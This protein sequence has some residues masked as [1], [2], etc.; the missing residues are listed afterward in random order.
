MFEKPIEFY[1]ALAAASLFV[2]ERSNDRPLFNR[3]LVVVISVGLGA[4]LSED[5][6]NWLGRSEI[7]VTVI[8]TSVGYLAL[9][10]LSSI[11]AD[12]KLLLEILKGRL[13]RK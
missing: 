4:S 7:L 8:I 10:F 13:G 6:A 3:L 5:L 9:D 1:I 11:F 12:R 2:Y